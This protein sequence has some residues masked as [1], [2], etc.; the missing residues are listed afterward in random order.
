MFPF[1]T[2]TT[3]TVPFVAACCCYDLA[4]WSCYGRLDEWDGISQ[5]CFDFYRRNADKVESDWIAE[6]WSVP[7]I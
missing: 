7:S 1:R 2:N 3:Y 5:D 6:F 4:F